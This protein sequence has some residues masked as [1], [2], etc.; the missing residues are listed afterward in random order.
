MRASLSSSALL[1]GSLNIVSMK[2]SGD[3]LRIKLAPSSGSPSQL[4]CLPRVSSFPS[5]YLRVDS[6]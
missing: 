3:L 1:F 2:I 4:W 5:N 6:V